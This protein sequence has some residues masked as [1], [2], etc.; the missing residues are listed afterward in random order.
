MPV[1]DSYGMVTRMLIHWMQKRNP[2]FTK[3]SILRTGKDDE[4][5]I[6]IYSVLEDFR[7]GRFEN[8][9][10]GLSNVLMTISL[11]R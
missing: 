3:D 10:V 6:R 5:G 9:K 7:P 11:L 4:R 2:A 8:H 1:S